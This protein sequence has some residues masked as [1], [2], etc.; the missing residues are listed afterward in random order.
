MGFFKVTWLSGGP[1]TLCFL[2]TFPISDNRATRITRGDESH[3]IQF[4]LLY[5]Q[6]RVFH[7]KGFVAQ[8]HSHS[9]SLNHVP[10]DF[11]TKIRHAPV[12]I[13]SVSKSRTRYFTIVINSTRVIRLL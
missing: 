8:S 4:S 1:K 5:L 3:A 12:S 9:F 13:S 7:P 2:S 11:E 6:L 10:F